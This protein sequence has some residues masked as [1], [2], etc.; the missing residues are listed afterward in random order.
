MV[1]GEKNIEGLGWLVRVRE[2]G[3]RGARLRVWY[4]GISMRAGAQDLVE[5]ALDIK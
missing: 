3:G 4:E 1:R 2:D 5:K